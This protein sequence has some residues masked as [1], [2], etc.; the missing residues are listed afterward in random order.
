[1]KTKTITMAIDQSVVDRYT[2]YYFEQHPRAHVP[3]IK[4]PYHES[5][6]QWMIMKRAAMN[7]LKQ[8]WKDFIK[9]FVN[10]QGYSNLR[11]ERCEIIQTVYYPTDRRHDTDNSVPKFILDGLVESQMIVDDD[12]EHVFRLTLECHIGSD[13]PRTELKFKIYDAG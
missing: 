12:C 3:P 5:I 11:I 4:R 6:N 2:K 13:K 8:K 9:W 1:M 10:D 7:G